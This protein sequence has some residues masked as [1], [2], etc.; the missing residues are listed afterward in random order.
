MASAKSARMSAT[1]IKRYKN[2]INGEWIDSALGEHFEN[3]NPANTNEVIGRFPRSGKE[4]VNKAVA[5]AKEALEIMAAV[6]RA[7]ARGDAFQCRRN[8]GS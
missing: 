1:K 7:Q 3:R 4:D 5:A 6:S 2:Y 8:S